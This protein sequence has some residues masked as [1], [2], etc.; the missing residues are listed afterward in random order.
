M[1]KVVQTVLD[2]E[3]YN[4]LREASSKSGVSIREAVKEAIANWS[5]ERSGI[6]ANDP[7]FSIKAV[8]FGDRHA[9]ERHDG[10]LYDEKS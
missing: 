3:E 8:P 1:K 9:A 2:E 10:V 7:I 6:D 4:A 5:E